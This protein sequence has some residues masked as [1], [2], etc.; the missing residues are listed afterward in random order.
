M[1]ESAPPPPDDELGHDAGDPSPVHE[2]PLP[3]LVLRC[4]IGGFFMGL[5]NLVPGISGGTMLLASGVYP[6]FIG[7]VAEVSRLVFHPIS[8]LVLGVVVAAKI[9][10]IVAGAGFVKDLVVDYRWVM[11]SLFIG[12]T[13]GG[14]PVIWRMIIRAQKAL[15][16]AGPG[17]WIA[18]GLGLVG[19]AILGVAQ[20]TE[21]ESSMQATGWALRGFMLAAGIAAASAMILPG[22]SGGYLLLLMGV[23]VPMLSGIDTLKD[24]VA[25]GDWALAGDASFNIVGPVV[26]GAVIGIVVVANVIKW[27]LRRFER[28]TLGVLLG[29]LLG[30]VVGLWP[31]RQPVPMDKIERIKGQAVHVVEGR[32]VYV[33]KPDEAIERED[34]PLEPFDPQWWHVLASLGLIGVGFAVTAA[35]DRIGGGD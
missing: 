29:L 24:A 27:L 7:A 9:T 15:P 4:A 21:V 18:A 5:A 3:L 26:I 8:M 14:V 30:A 20:T 23:Y 31:F 19:M 6:R 1:A 22:I 33:E 13:L 10:A 25:S 17:P 11:F 32:L 16:N 34:H 12:L 2:P 35:V 28:A